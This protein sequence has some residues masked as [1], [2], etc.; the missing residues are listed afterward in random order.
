[1]ADAQFADLIARYGIGDLAIDGDDLPW[2]PYAGFE[3]SFFKPLRFDVRNNLVIEIGWTQGPGVVG[4]HQHHGQVIAYTLEGSWFYREHD[5]VAKA[6]TLVVEAPGAIHTLETKEG[7]KALFMDHGNID[8]FGDD[9][10]YAGTQ[11]V[12][13][14][15][16]AYERHCRENGLE[17]DRRLYA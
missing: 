6:G 5:W 1:M 9:G 12:W 4:R 2:V 15:I 16:D 3:G 8:F 10:S 14:W 11:T 13:W 7:F 17:I